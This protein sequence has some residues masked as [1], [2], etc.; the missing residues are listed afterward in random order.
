MR[1]WFFSKV[2][3]F[4]SEMATPVNFCLIV[5]TLTAVEFWNVIPSVFPRFKFRFWSV[6]LTLK[7]GISFGFWHTPRNGISLEAFWVF[8]IRRQAI[9][10][11]GLSNLVP[12]VYYFYL[13]KEISYIHAFIHSC[14]CSSHLNSYMFAFF[15]LYE[16]YPLCMTKVLANQFV[17][18]GRSHPSISRCTLCFILF[19][20]C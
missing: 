2:T 17:S 7:G 20:F 16:L 14:I 6:L 4:S 8:M 12:T 19:L 9:F 18:S 1:V 5:C 11:F 15:L 10:F 3:G 13:T